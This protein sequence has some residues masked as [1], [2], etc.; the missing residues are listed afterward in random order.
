MSLYE[1]RLRL[2]GNLLKQVDRE[3]ELHLQ[4]WLMREIKAERAIGKDKSELVYKRF[5]KFFDYDARISKVK[6]AGGFKACDSGLRQVAR[7]LEQ[8]REEGADGKL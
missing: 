8:L 6:K 4:A 3:Y 1:Y 2:Q 7:R 5:D